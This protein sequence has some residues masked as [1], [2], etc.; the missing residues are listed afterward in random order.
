MATHVKA[1][2]EFTDWE[3]SLG[4]SLN[5]GDFGVARVWTWKTFS[6]IIKETIVRKKKDNILIENIEKQEKKDTFAHSENDCDNN[7]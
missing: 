7:I 2:S 5:F 4:T 6:K 1:K 3:Y